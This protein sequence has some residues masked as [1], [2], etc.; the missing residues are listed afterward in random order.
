MKPSKLLILIIFFTNL[1][2]AQSSYIYVSPKPNS[3]FV[4]SETNIILKS[5]SIVDRASLA[6][7]LISVEGSQSG[8]HSG[9]LILSDDERTIVFNP[10]KPFSQNEVVNVYMKDGIKTINAGFLSA[11]SFSFTIMPQSMQPLAKSI[12]E[13]PLYKYNAADAYLPA[14]PITID[15]VNNPSPGYIFLAT[16]DR[17]APQHVYAN[18]IFILDSLGNI[19]DSTRV[20]GAPFDFQIQGNGL[21]SYGLGAYAGITP[22]N[23]NLKQYVLDSNLAI[24]DS[25]QMKNGYLTDFHDFILLPNGHAM[26]MSYHTVTF[27]MSQVVPGGKTDALLVIDVFQEQD[28][29]KNVVFE[30]RDI[31]YIPITDTDLN[32]TDPRV[33]PS[34]LNSFDLD[35]DGNLLLSFRNHSD[36]MK[37]SRETGEVIWR[38]GGLKNEFTFIN[39]HP[40]NAPYYF[41]RQHDVHRLPNGNISIF[42]NGEFHSPWYS[43]STEYI[44]DELNK[45]ATLV[46]EY[47]YS[48]GD[49]RTQAAG[50]AQRLSNG[51]WFVGY[52]IL[53]PSTPVRRNIVETHADGSTAFELTLPVN[54]VSYRVSKQ[55]WKQL[56]QKV[57]ITWA[58]VLQGNTY[59]FNKDGKNTGVSIKYTALTGDSYNSVSITR[60]PYGPVKPEFISDAPVI[61]PVSILYS[62]AA[63]SSHTSEIH[64]DLNEYP[65]IKEP[66][67]TSI[68]MREF[69]SQGLF[70]ELPTIYDSLANELIANTAIF[71]EIVF[72]QSDVEQGLATP[73]LIEPLNNKKVL[74]GQSLLL[75]W[76]GRG[77][78]QSFTLQIAA[79]SLFSGIILDTLTT[80]S[81]VQKANLLKDQKYFWRVRANTSTGTGDWSSIWSF[82][83]ADAFIKILTPNGN[84]SVEAG[85]PF[86]IRWDTNIRDSVRIYLLDGAAETLLGKTY[87]TN[88]ALQW[89]VPGDLS[90]SLFYKVSIAPFSF[91]ALTDTSDNS[92]TILGPVAV[93]P[94]NNKLPVSFQLMQNYPNPFN[95]TTNFGF[96]I[97][98]FGFVSIKVYDV[99]GREVKTLVNEEIPA[100]SYKVIFDAGDLSSGVY[101]YKMQAGSFTDTK[102]FIL[103]R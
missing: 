3:I 51:G 40:E 42:D 59:L 93:N 28:A 54:V 86:I 55:P 102:K 10:Y 82:E 60:I 14:P 67:K 33:N 37:I 23:S 74:A 26:L 70:L 13:D 61:K 4:S 8:M 47:R 44:V 36:I 20:N 19:I 94:E 80:N 21:L 69:Q 63:I 38:W 101:F 45:T 72:G 5:S 91:P 11:Y 43:R 2:Y 46:S 48:S 76:G 32:L 62:G 30:W 24:I 78:L 77:L 35:N 98:E 16:W 81:F 56:I 75:K 17:N 53:D 7:D 71:G 57:M 27:D 85:N 66:R 22:G 100:G 18:Y 29:E 1:I 73:V 39:D 99:L 25:F 58:E 95:P 31:D 50:S 41:A 34:T 97:S 64:I 83:P 89:N 49:I 103:L 12:S 84:D 92:F 6:I 15:S 79:D 88:S 96:R 9:D 90:N 68:Y 52:G 87:G 65:E